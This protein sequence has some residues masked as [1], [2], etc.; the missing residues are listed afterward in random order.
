MGQVMK[1][2]EDAKDSRRERA[3]QQRS[4]RSGANAS[5][6]IR[7]VDWI[8]VCALIIGFYESGGA[9]R[10]GATRDGGA[11]A[12]GC[13]HGDD[14]ATEYIRPAED[15]TAAVTEIAEAWLPEGGVSYHQ[16]YN[17]LSN[18]AG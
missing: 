18:K 5:A 6:G 12:I 1:A 17:F 15:F 11:Y 13:Y 8:A 14:Y 9:V 3:K 7:T 16:A 10:I 2:K 4:K